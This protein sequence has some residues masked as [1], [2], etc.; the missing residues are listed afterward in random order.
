VAAVKPISTPNALYYG[1]NLEVLRRDISTESVDLIYLDPPFNSNRSYNV[2]FKHKTGREAQAQI[3]AFDDTWTWSQEAEHEY[4][5][6]IAGQVPAKVADALVAMRGLLGDN[7]VLA[8]LVMMTSRLVELHRVLKPTG[9]LYLHCDPTASHYLKVMLD[10]IFGPEHFVNEVIWKRSS[11]HSDTKQGSK[12]FG[13]VSD[14]ILFYAKSNSP[15]RPWNTQY[16]PYDQA[17]IDRDYRRADPD[18]RRYRISDMSGPGGAAK[19]NP[20]Y[21]VMGVS[22]YWRYSKETM[23]E[24]IAEG[25]VVQTRPGAVP[26]LKRYLDE[27]PG[28]PVQNIWTDVPVINNRSK[29]KLGYPTQKP[30]ALLE[31]ILAA[32]SNPGDVVLD[33]FCGCGTTID[34]AEKLDRRWIGIDITYLAVDLIDKRLRH[35]HGEDVTATYEIVG[36]PRDVGGARALFHRNPFDFERW[37]VSMVDGQPNDK[38][39]GDKGID[40]VVRFATDAKGGT[41]RILVSVKGGKQVNPAMVRDLI[42]TVDGHKAA[43]GILVTLEE[44]TKG[45]VEAAHHSGIYTLHV[46]GQGFPKV[47]IITVEQLLAGRRP[48]TPPTLMPYT[49]AQ[50]HAV[51]ADQMTLG[52]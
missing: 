2:L 37:A 24:L 11:A 49:Q 40:G 33:P 8:Y 9:S 1:D 45:M 21:E 35:S 50:R 6:M 32:S 38:Q 48:R 15:D 36:I 10:T 29:E 25:R 42:G 39:V 19:G 52:L 12:H 41:E 13:R 34:A 46:N 17:Y 47:Q 27:M 5:A 28:V 18:G 3:E 44:P 31:R 20:F 14:T 7:D 26:Q 23:D 30:L 43:M 51:G 22:R 16:Q 4:L